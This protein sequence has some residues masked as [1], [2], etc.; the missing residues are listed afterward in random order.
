MHAGYETMDI[1]LWTGISCV[2]FLLSFS[3][4]K[5]ELKVLKLLK[6]LS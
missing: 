6:E 3:H 1:V 4:S 2:D 5:I